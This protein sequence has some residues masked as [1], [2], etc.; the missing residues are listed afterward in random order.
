MLLR[1]NHRQF[2]SLRISHGTGD[3]TQQQNSL[4]SCHEALDSMPKTVRKG[5]RGEKL[6]KKK[7]KAT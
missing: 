7:K 2:E 6:K 1:V 4:S 3:V 5:G